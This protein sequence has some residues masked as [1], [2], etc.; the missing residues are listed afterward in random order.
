MVIRLKDIAADL[1][2]SMVTVSKV[3]RNKSDVSVETR[4]RILQRVEEVNYRP[5]LMARGLASGRSYTVGL[6][7]PDIADLFF[8]EFAKSLGAALRTHSYQLVVASA[9]EQPDVERLEIDNLLGRGVDAILV[10]SCQS[11]REGLHAI[12][13]RSVPCVLIDRRIKG[14][15]S[16][17]IGTDDLY[18][19]HI[20]TTHLIGLGRKRIA[21]IGGLGT[22]PAIERFTG[23]KEALEQNAVPFREE[24][25]ILNNLQERGDVLGRELM[26]KLLDLPKRPNAVFCYND[27]LALG[28]I[29]SVRAHG[30]RVPEDVAIIGCGNL[31]LSAYLEVPLSSVDQGTQQLGERAAKLALSLVESK[32]PETPR[33]TLIQPRVVARASTLGSQPGRP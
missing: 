30:L 26:D 16:H 23:Y 11:D 2:V 24:L 27:L 1:G 32:K 9:D 31:S 14:F 10:A 7:V 19:G 3:L 22:S 28:A 4:R 15:K 8:A 5:N 6:V 21:H 25:V 20:A 12:A 29:H 13:E 17:Y 33:A 18:A